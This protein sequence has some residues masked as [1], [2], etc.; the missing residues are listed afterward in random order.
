MKR[1]TG[2]EPTALSIA[3]RVES[4]RYRWARLS[5]GDL[6]KAGLE[7]C[8][9]AVAAA[10]RTAC[11]SSVDDSIGLANIVGGIWFEQE[12]E[13]GGGG[14]ALRELGSGQKKK[15]EEEGRWFVWI[16]V[17][18]SASLVDKCRVSQRSFML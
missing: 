18:A 8:A 2:A 13:E 15:E 12:L 5:I 11:R 9:V 16:D 17:G 4:E 6:T 1:T 10:G 14:G 7:N 3:W